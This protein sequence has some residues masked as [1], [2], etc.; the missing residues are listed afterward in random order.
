M[1]PPNDSADGNT[2][3]T[4]IVRDEASHKRRLLAFW[5][6]GSANFD[7]PD[8]G[9][10]TIGRGTDC[11]VR[12][13]HPSVSRRHVKLHLGKHLRLEDLG[14]SNGTSVAGKTIPK[15]E[16][17]P[18]ESGIVIELGSAMLLVQGGDTTSDQQAGP[19][20]RV[21]VVDG[22]PVYRAGL[23]EAI[24]QQ[25]ELE[26]V[27]DAVRADVLR[28]LGRLER[29]KREAEIDAFLWPGVT[30]DLHAHRRRRHAHR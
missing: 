16:S 17:V 13:D 11:Q 19:V 30:L 25:P 18:I 23:I 5:K 26:G 8:H 10:V 27:F 9:A 29:G 21:A 20:L 1:R 12:I 3:A 15:G 14:S 2:R 4:T 24:R 22:Q 28:C 6:H 7:L